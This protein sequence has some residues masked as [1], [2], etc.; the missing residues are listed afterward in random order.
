MPRVMPIYQ[1]PE[2]TV[3]KFNP[4]ESP[5]KEIILHNDDDQR[6]K[7]TFLFSIDYILN[8]AG[9]KNYTENN[10]DN[11]NS[12]NYEWLNCTRFKPPKLDSKYIITGK[13]CLIFND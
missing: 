4:P 2:P 7:P 11:K 8:K 5:E 13:V 3:V 6:R 10:T 12:Q 1:K 9:E